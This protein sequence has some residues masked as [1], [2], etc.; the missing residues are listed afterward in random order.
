M[1]NEPDAGWLLRPDV[2]RKLHASVTRTD[3]DLRPCSSTP[4]QYSSAAELAD[5]LPDG[6][7][8]LDHAGKPPIAAAEIDDWAR[9]ITE[10]ARRPNVFCKL[11]GLVTEAD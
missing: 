9:A 7:L 4:A 5:R 8:V 3:A 1:E 6:R 2:L 11:S 10:I